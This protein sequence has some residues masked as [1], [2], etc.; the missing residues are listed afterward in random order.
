[1]LHTEV[2]PS[3]EGVQSRVYTSIFVKSN[4]QVINFYI[5]LLL[6]LKKMCVHFL[7]V[8]K[9]TFSLMV[10]HTLCICTLT[11]RYTYMYTKIATFWSLMRISHRRDIIRC[12]NTVFL[13]LTCLLR[14]SII[15]VIWIFFLPI[16][17]VFF[18]LLLP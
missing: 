10:F 16:V 9:S 12:S 2:K 15:L 17:P 6:N 8:S 5:M 18:S 7:V 14:S 11:C 13:L 4:P 3:A 1:M